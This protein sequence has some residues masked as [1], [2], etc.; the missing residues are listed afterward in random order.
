VTKG[1][2]FQAARSANQTNEPL[3]EKIMTLEEMREKAIELMIK[4]FH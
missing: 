3:E 4:R 1:P 2:C